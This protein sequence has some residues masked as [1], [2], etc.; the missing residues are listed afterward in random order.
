M[1]T[2]SSINRIA[3]KTLP[4]GSQY[5][6]DDYRVFLII[7]EK[8]RILVE[9][10]SDKQVFDLLLDEISEKFNKSVNNIIIETSDLIENKSLQVEPS[11]HL[12]RREKLK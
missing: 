10:S 9:G 11:S 6:I 4:S 3:D 7:E 1:L 5:T 2:D 8:N 12:G